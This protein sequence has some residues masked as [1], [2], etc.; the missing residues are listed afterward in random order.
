MMILFSFAIASA[1]ASMKNCPTA[2]KRSDTD[3]HVYLVTIAG[4][5]APWQSFGHSTL[6]ISDGRNKTDYSYNWGTFDPNQPNLIGAFLQGKMNYWL[7]AVEFNRD[8]YRYTQKEQRTF[9]A[10]RLE[11][12]QDQAIELTEILKEESKPENRMFTYDWAT[13]S[14]ATK[15]RDRLNRVLDDQLLQL[16][17]TPAPRTMRQEGLRYLHG[18]PELWFL[19]DRAISYSADVPVT[20]WDTAYSPYMLSQIFDQVQVEGENQSLPFVKYSCEIDGTYPMPP[21]DP[22]AHHVPLGLFSLCSSIV[23]GFVSL[24]KGIAQTTA[25]SFFGIISFLLGIL[26]TIH[27]L[28]WFSKLSYLHP[29]TNTLISGPQVLL[30]TLLSV[31]TIRDRE[32]QSWAV[33]LIQCFSVIGILTSIW[34]ISPFGLQDN[35]AQ[36]CLF[37]PFHILM[38]Y[39]TNK[40]RV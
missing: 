12:S 5:P 10:Q 29:N 34:E 7:N 4:T 14:C 38:L 17:Q 3:V 31:Q 30:W 6:W 26:V 19:W 13:K 40:G 9:I 36:I 39:L 21:E 18:K 33:R 22:P 35:T 2:K 25:F 37:L 16:K 28:L 32:L 1:V 24:K 27:T 15:I 8:F 23:L 20:L 11:L